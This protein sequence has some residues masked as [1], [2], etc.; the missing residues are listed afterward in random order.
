MAATRISSDPCGGDGA[1]R[2]AVDALLIWRDLGRDAGL[3]LRQRVRR[4]VH[5]PVASALLV[6]VVKV[7]PVPSQQE[8]R[9]RVDERH[10]CGQ[11]VCWVGVGV[12]SRGARAREPTGAVVG[13]GCVCVCVERKERGGKGCRAPG[14]GTRRTQRLGADRAGAFGDGAQA[15]A[16]ST[17]VVAL[18]IR[19]WEDSSARGHLCAKE[20]DAA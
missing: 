9:A 14:Y 3:A 8:A 12:S 6:S 1:R 20:A 18:A 5:G 11:G 10:A 13:F 17:P 16:P 7:E 2:A 15:A 19:E 4:V